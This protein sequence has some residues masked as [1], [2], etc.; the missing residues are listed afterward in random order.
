MVAQTTTVGVD[1][2]KKPK[3]L[4]TCESEGRG[5]GEGG[6]VYTTLPQSGT[7]QGY[8][9]SKEVTTPVGVGVSTEEYDVV[10]SRKAARHL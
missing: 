8:G 9:R 2:Y 7:V 3:D 10:C 6:G 5:H 1:L 4:S